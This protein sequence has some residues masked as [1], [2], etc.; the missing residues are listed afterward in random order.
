MEASSR[1]YDQIFF[2]LFLC[3]AL[4]GCG[5][6]GGGGGAVSPSPSASSSEGPAPTEH[7]T[8]QPGTGM[9]ADDSPTAP[10][11]A[12]CAEIVPI[13]P[14]TVPENQT[15]HQD[16][17]LIGITA[18]VNQTRARPADLD[19]LKNL[20]YSWEEWKNLYWFKRVTG[21]YTGSTEM[22]LRFVACKYGIDEDAIRAQATSERSSWQQWNAG[23][24]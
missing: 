24:I 10:T 9:F 7:F 2:A 16:D 6:G 8:T 11:D 14:E 5:G 1:G 13:T 4:V 20:N 23:A 15:A 22:I 21:Q 18:P 19:R 3:V 12:Q 17:L